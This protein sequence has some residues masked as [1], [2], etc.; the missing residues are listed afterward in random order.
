[1]RNSHKF[2]IFIT[3]SLALICTTLR[4]EAVDVGIFAATVPENAADV[5]NKLLDTGLFNTV[6]VR[7]VGTGT[8][9]VTLAEL[10]N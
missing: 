5:Q 6:D 8:P 10:Q 4:A 9:P 7:F 1:M 3:L 2:I